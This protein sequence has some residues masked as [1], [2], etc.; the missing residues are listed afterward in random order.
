M[1]NDM[2]SLEQDLNMLAAQNPEMAPPAA[3][4]EADQAP[5]TTPEP[6]AN[7]DPAAPPAEP[8]APELKGY[9][10]EEAAEL[11]QRAAWAAMRTE[12]SSLKQ[13]LQQLAQQ[14]NIDVSHIDSKD[15]QGLISVLTQAQQPSPK[16][17]VKD[18]PPEVQQ[19]LARLQ[20][21]ARAAEQENLRVITMQG[22][23]SVQN[24]YGL[25]QKDLEAFADQL[26]A[27]GLNPYTTP[28]NLT[29][30]YKMLN[31]DKIIAAEVDKRIAE[32]AAEAERQDA[33][34]SQPSNTNGGGAPAVEDKISN[35]LDLDKMLDGFGK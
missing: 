32:Q 34:A 16:P 21:Q 12:N 9:T 24:E 10:P 19:E 28:V 7:T 6:D 15:V 3:D 4:P 27:Q 35:L 33:H 22:F 23:Q 14:Q 25:T 17:D 30:A 20:Q 29:Q 31:T 11:K 18:I 5:P 8:P 2:A 13:A 1:N 26:I